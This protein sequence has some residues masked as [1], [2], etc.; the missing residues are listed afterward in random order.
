MELFLIIVAGIFVAFLLIALTIFLFVKFWVRRL[1]KQFTDFADNAAMGIAPFMQPMRIRLI[2]EVNPGWNDEDA[3][4]R[5]VGPLR[6][7]GFEEAGTFVM[8]EVPDVCLQAWAQS[9]KSV[10]AVIYEH[11]DRGVWF[12]FVSRYEDGATLTHT[13]APASGLD[14]PP[15][16]IL[17]RCDADTD[18]TKVYQAHLAARPDKPLLP[19]TPKQFKPDF[20]RS[21]AAEMDWR[22][23][24]GG[25]TEAEI[26][27][28]LKAIGNETTDL[29]IKQVHAM[30][31]AQVNIWLQ[32]KLKENFRPNLSDEKWRKVKNR[33]IFIHDR[34]TG[35]ELHGLYMNCVDWDDEDSQ[36]RADE[37]EELSRDGSARSA[38]ARM[39]LTLP[40][41]NMPKKIGHLTEPIAADVYVGPNVAD[42][43]FEE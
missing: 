28:N 22:F 39:I 41:G 31:Q 37:A 26:R 14:R 1:F 43:A 30:Q 19:A 3:V 23:E 5:V 18:S 6:K 32:T 29:Q 27:K 7:A 40:A 13:T 11:P 35:E 15:N 33:L 36:E 25:F 4:H 17:E 2:R 42:A 34:L 24:R 16:N 21:Y 10:Y 9:E 20:E 38:F 8:E 12:E